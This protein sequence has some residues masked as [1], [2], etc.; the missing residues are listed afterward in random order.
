MYAIVQLVVEEAMYNGATYIT[1]GFKTFEEA[2]KAFKQE[3]EEE[4][5][6]AEERGIDYEEDF[7]E[8]EET[9]EYEIRFDDYGTKYRII[10][11]SKKFNAITF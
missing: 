9:M 4:K 3:I 1:T 5:R 8:D 6:F 11:L 7:Y 10:D 2:K